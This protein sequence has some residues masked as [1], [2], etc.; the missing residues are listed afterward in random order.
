[1]IRGLIRHLPV[2]PRARVA[3]GGRLS[4]AYPYA[5]ADPYTDADAKWH[6][7]SRLARD[8]LCRS[9]QRAIATT[10]ITFRG[11]FYFTA[12]IAAT[13]FLFTQEST[14]CDLELL[15]NGATRVTVEDSAGT[16][17]VNG[18]S[19]NPAGSV[20]LNAWAAF[21]FDVNMATQTAVVTLNGG[22]PVTLNFSTPGTGTF[23]N[24]REVSFLANTAGTS[25]LQNGARFR[26]LSVDFNGTLHKAISSEAALANADPWKRG[27]T[28][29]DL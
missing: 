28:V 22:A 10:R 7:R 1:M 20:A 19:A 9:R 24:A 18:L 23:T 27:G 4:D 15:T 8:I 26:N 13:T 6:S 16:K 11:E 29:T 14:G 25:P 12:P 3:V 21:V 2:G 17:L 5:Y